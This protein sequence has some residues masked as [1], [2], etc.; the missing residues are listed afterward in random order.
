M[1]EEKEIK[2]FLMT[3]SLDS[4]EKLKVVADRE[5]RSVV[6]QVAY[7]IYQN[8]A[9]YEADNGKIVGAYPMNNGIFTNNQVGNNSLKVNN[10][11]EKGK[12]EED[13]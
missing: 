8:L 13:K 10:G 9:K 5:Q 12:T 11:G 4:Y 6:G 2:K 7:W 3:I 1:A